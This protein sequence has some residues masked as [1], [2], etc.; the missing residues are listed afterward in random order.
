MR[1]VHFAAFAFIAATVPVA[2]AQTADDPNEGQRLSLDPATGALELSWWGRTGRIYFIE[3][4]ADLFLWQALP[5]FEVGADAPISFG[6][7]SS[8]PRFF[9]RVRWINTTL[10]HFLIGDYDGDG[11]SNADEAAAGLNPFSA[12][13]DGDSMPD[14]WELA[15][16]LDPFADDSAGDLDADGVRNDRDARPAN[17]S[18]GELQVSIQSPAPNAHL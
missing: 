14:G 11:V 6:L 3:H 16:G 12:D 15:F 4:S 5:V 2:L 8:G 18:I 9:S 10:A 13:S 17:P 7:V 1:T